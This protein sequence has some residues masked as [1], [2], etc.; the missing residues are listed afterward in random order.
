VDQARDRK[1]K[2]QGGWIGALTIFQLSPDTFRLGVC[3]LLVP[4]MAAT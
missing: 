2:N 1:V 3:R 4:G